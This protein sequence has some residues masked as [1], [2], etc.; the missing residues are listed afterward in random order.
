[1]TIDLHPKMVAGVAGTTVGGALALIT[2]WVLGLGGIPVPTDVTISFSTVFN[3]LVG[4]VAAYL[5]PS[6]AAPPPK[7]P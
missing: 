2:V 7:G 4:G 1:M 6:P 5:T 3:V